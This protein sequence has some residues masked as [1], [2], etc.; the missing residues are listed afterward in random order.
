[1]LASVY[2]CAS[3]ASLVTDVSL[4]LLDEQEPGLGFRFVDENCPVAD[5]ATQVADD[6]VAAGIA[7]FVDSLPTRL[8]DIV[9]R[10]YWLG[11][12]QTEI[13]EDL[14][15][16]RSAVCHAIGKVTRLGRRHFGIVEH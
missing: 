1:M 2:L 8:R 5:V 10:H 6:E 11:Q 15:V 7:R 9:H 12:S 16:T 13:A 4:D 14:G 3:R